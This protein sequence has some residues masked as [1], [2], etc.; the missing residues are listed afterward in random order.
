MHIE[1]V[2]GLFLPLFATFAKK[3]LL[4][5]SLYYEDLTAAEN[6]E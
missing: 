2:Y 4:N 5:L 1:I 3:K 6:A